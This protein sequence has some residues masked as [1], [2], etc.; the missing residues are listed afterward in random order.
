M[1][2]LAEMQS[3]KPSLRKRTDSSDDSTTNAADKCEMVQ[4]DA[5]ENR[6]S[7]CYDEMDAASNPVVYLL[8]L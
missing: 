2:A 3:K 6:C 8:E 5:L 1:A 4:T 7:I